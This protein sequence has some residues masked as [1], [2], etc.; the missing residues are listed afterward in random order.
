MLDLDSLKNAQKIKIRYQ[1]R[2]HVL[3]RRENKKQILVKHSVEMYKNIST[4]V[5]PGGYSFHFL[6]EFFF[7]HI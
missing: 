6:S 1:E 4:F 2:V 3:I 5:H 7:L